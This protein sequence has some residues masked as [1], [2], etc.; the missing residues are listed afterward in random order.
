MKNS[1]LVVFLMTFATLAHSAW[2]T[3][4]LPQ[5]KDKSFAVSAWAED[6]SAVQAGEAP[7]AIFGVGCESSGNRWV[8]LRLDRSSPN[9]RNASLS[10][11]FTWGDIATYTAPLTYYPQADT[12]FLQRSTDDFISLIQGSKSVSVRL[13]W[14]NSAAQTFTFA[15]A[16]SSK[17]IE[18]AFRHCNIPKT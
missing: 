5:I 6:T 2:R 15:L 8:Y 18:Q 12:L 1:I 7:R 11:E 17:A 13:L 14:D 16:G 9:A 4:E 3:V 10:G